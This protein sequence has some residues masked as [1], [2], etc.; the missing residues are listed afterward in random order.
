MVQIENV[1]EENGLEIDDPSVQTGVER[2][3][4]L[5][6]GSSVYCSI[7]YRFDCIIC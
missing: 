5:Y 2:C 6:C 1:V 7:L 3:L 4:S